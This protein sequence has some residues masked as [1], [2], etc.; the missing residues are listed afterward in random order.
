LGR[1]IYNL[2]YSPYL[3]I[4][5]IKDEGDKSQFV[6]VTTAALT[7]V[8]IYIIL[9]VIYDLLKYGRMVSVTGKVFVIM[10]IIQAVVLLY[11]G[12]WT[13]QVLKKEK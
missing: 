2:Y 8:I 12:Y 1:N 9:R 5:R 4:K 6:L 10:G 7:P 3:T 13:L 11:L